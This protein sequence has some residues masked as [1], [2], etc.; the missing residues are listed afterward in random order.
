MVANPGADGSGRLSPIRLVG[1]RRLRRLLVQR[2]PIADAAA[3]E[4]RPLRYHRE[5]VGLLGQ[6]PPQ[7]RLVPAELVQVA[8]AMSSDAPP[9]RFDLLDQLIARHP[10]EVLVHS[11]PPGKSTRYSRASV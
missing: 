3:Q 10:V 1:P 9:Q 5:G 6:Q 7:R 2:L 11:A 4:L 8:V